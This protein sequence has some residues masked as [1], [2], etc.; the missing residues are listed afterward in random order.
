MII[1]D[2][3]YE[4]GDVP[5]C[6]SAQLEQ[7]AVRLPPPESVRPW[8]DAS[9][10][11]NRKVG[12]YAPPPPPPHPLIAFCASTRCSHRHSVCCIPP[13]QFIEL[14]G[15]TLSSDDATT[16]TYYTITEA[17]AAALRDAT[18]VR[19]GQ[20]SSNGLAAHLRLCTLPR[21]ST[22]ISSPRLTLR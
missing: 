19:K 3:L 22:N 1:S 5:N 20:A 11:Y 13:S 15:Q 4:F 2:E 16:A 7:R 17:G 12:K 18:N 21:R 8:L 6:T 10:A 14:Y 9:K